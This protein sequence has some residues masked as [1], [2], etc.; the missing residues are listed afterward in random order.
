MPSTLLFWVRV[1]TP[2]L[3]F[4]SR[5]DPLAFVGELVWWCWILWAFACLLISPSY[6]NE[7][8]A[9][10]SNLGCRF[11]SFITLSMS[12]PSLLAWRVS[13]ERSA[14]ILVGIPFVLFVVFPLLLLIFVLCVWSLL[15]WLICVL[16]CFALGLSCFEL[17][18]ILDLGDYFLAHFREV[19]NYYLL[20][21]FLM[22]F[23]FVFFF[24]DSY[25]SNVG[26]F[27][28]VPE[29]SEFVLISINSFFFFPLCCNY[30]QHSI[31]YLTYPISASII[32][33]LV[34]SGRLLISFIALFTIYWLFYFFQVLQHFW[35]LLNPCLQAIYL[36]LHFVFKIWDHFHYH[37]S[38]FFIR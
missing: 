23:L 9:G 36:W 17:F 10:Y 32:L 4:L 25:D 3:C 30:F 24:W 18:E 28:I 34:P 33:L 11:F 15:I 37:Y 8:L 35:H 20:K 31:F 2:F 12:C 26:V 21:Y 38:Q 14:V 6:L 16:G 13:I 22:V 7:I 5:E 27:N 1:Y 29:V 19:F